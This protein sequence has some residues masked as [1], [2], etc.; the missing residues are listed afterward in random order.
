MPLWYANGSYPEHYRFTESKRLRILRINAENGHACCIQD[1]KR[2]NGK[3]QA[4]FKAYTAAAL[5]GCI[6]SGT[7]HLPGQHHIS[8]TEAKDKIIGKIADV[9]ANAVYCIGQSTKTRS[10]PAI[11]QHTDAF[12]SQLTEN[13][14]EYRHKFPPEDFI[15]QLQQTITE[16]ALML[17]YPDSD[18]KSTKRADNRADCRAAHAPAGKTAKAGNEK[19]IADD[20]HYIADNIAFHNSARPSYTQQGSLQQK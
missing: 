6:I 8:L 14:A 15:R 17:H 20:I 1:N 5:P 2:S 11:G 13:T 12:R 4:P 18:T 7:T 9:I 16:K 19:I 10:H 3:S